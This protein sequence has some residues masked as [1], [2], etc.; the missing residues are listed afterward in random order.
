MKKKVNSNDNHKFYLEHQEHLLDLC[1]GYL[2]VKPN[3][4][5]IPIVFSM[6]DDY[7]YI[8]SDDEASDVV[9]NVYIYKPIREIDINT[10]KKVVNETYKNSLEYQ[11]FGRVIII[12]KENPES[13]F[14]FSYL[15]EDKKEIKSMMK[16]I[17]L[18][19]KIKVQHKRTKVSSSTKI[20]LKKTQR[21]HH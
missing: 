13:P 18:N 3:S 8:Y 9:N 21:G 14:T 1:Y 12:F 19:T 20:K 11:E 6:D 10:V 5:F 4:L 15:K 7:L 2:Q 17:R 16:T